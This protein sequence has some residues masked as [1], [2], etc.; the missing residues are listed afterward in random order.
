VTDKLEMLTV[1][2]PMAHVARGGCQLRLWP[3]DASRM[4]FMWDNQYELAPMTSSRHIIGE[5][6]AA[7]TAD[8]RTNLVRNAT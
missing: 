7:Q 4:A 6:I 8:D 3:S 1:S 5:G 2:G